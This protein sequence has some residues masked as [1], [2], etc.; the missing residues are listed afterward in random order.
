MQLTKYKD[1]E[2]E[3]IES[4]YQII[5]HDKYRYKKILSIGF[6][7]SSGFDSDIHWTGKWF[8]RI[9]IKQQLIEERFAYFDDGIDFKYK[10]D[11]WTPKWKF[12]K[13]IN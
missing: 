7:I 13:L 6:I 4:K 12:I 10:W 2:I 5:R 9:R 1:I 11:E 3:Q 8:K